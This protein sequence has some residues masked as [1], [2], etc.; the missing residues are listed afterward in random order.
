[1]VKGLIEIYNT[2]WYFQIQHKDVKAIKFK[3]V[4][5]TAD[6][7]LDKSNGL[8]RHEYSTSCNGTSSFFFYSM[9]FVLY[10]LWRFNYFTA[11]LCYNLCKILTNTIWPCFCY[12]VILCFGVICPHRLQMASILDC[13]HY[14]TIKGTTWSI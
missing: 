1:M 3:C 2:K 5:L 10:V 8:F 13:F 6:I 4:T 14:P 12:H 7:V 11:F 9:P